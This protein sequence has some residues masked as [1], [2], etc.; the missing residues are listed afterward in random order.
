VSARGVVAA[1]QGLQLA[2]LAVRGVKA[3]RHDTDAHALLLSLVRQPEA[4]DV[5]GGVEQHMVCGGGDATGEPCSRLCGA[6]DEL[7]G[8]CGIFRC[9]ACTRKLMHRHAP[10]CVHLCDG[11]FYDDEDLS[12]CG[13]CGVPAAGRPAVSANGFCEN[14][15]QFCERCN[16][17]FCNE[18]SRAHGQL[19]VCGETGCAS[20]IGRLCEICNAD[21][22]EGLSRCD[23][24]LRGVVCADC[25]MRLQAACHGCGN[26][27]CGKCRDEHLNTVE[28]SGC[29]SDSDESDS[30]VEHV[31]LCNA[32]TVVA[33]GDKEA[34]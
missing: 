29:E 28:A 15:R 20:W 14:C 9:S 7:C 16:A 23:G 34:E 5:S 25:V 1:L 10:T 8:L 4:L 24:C 26:T 22:E 19:L 21:A 32:C 30:D 33:A 6:E 18:C 3:E 2:Q 11:C 27:F 12:I 17:S 31:V 13:R